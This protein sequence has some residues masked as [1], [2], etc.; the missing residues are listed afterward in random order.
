M[1]DEKCHQF[2]QYLPFVGLA[3]GTDTSKSPMITRM[4][5]A[6]IMSAVAGGFALYVSV[7]V[8]K[9]ELNNIANR[10]EAVAIQVEKVDQKVERVRNDLYIPRG[11]N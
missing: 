7:E 4:L 3:M 10:V 11:S 5:E 1:P 6:A 8:I 9:G 2:A